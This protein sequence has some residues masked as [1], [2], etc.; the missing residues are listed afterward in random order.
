MDLSSGSPAPSGYIPTTS[1][2]TALCLIPPRHLWPSLERL[3]CRYDS[4]YDKWPPHINLV[5]PFVPIQDLPA[6]VERVVAGL[7]AWKSKRGP[8]ASDIQLNL[9]A[10]SY[11]EHKHSNTIYL[12]DSDPDRDSALTQLRSSV[13][14]GLGHKNV[15]SY[16]AHMSVGQT[17]DAQSDAHKFLMEKLA[18]LPAQQWSAEHL[19]VLTRD[20]EGQGPSMMRFWGAI[21]LRQTRLVQDASSV[22]LYEDRA[23]VR[24]ATRAT[25]VTNQTY[26]YSLSDETWI[27]AVTS[28]PNLLVASPETLIVATYNVLAEFIH[29]I[30]RERYPLLIDNLLGTAA[31]A[32]ILVLQEVT[33]DFLTHLLADDRLRSRYAFVSHGPP[34]QPDLDPLP[35]LL[36]QVILSKF[37]FELDLLPLKKQHKVSLIATFPSIAKQQADGVHHPLVLATCHLSRGLTDGAVSTKKGELQ[38]IIEHL[39][40]N[41]HDSPWILAGDFNLATSR[42]TINAALEKRSI[43]QHTVDQIHSIEQML[44]DCGLSDAWAVARC[45]VGES[46][47]DFRRPKDVRQTY[48]GEQGATFDPT[49]NKLAAE[50]VGTGFGNRPQRYDRILVKADGLFHVAGFSMFGFPAAATDNISGMPCASDHWGVR[51]L[52]RATSESSGVDSGPMT[53][54][55]ETKRAPEGLGGPEELKEYLSEIGGFPTEEDEAARTRAFE[56]LKSAILSAIGP[57]STQEDGRERQG[58]PLVVTPVGSFALGVW[59]RDSDVDCLCIGPF[60][61]RTFFSVVTRYLR[62]A[63]GIRVLRKV[64]ANTGV[65]LELEVGGV[66]MDLQY[67]AAASIAEGW[68]TVMNRPATDP[69]FSLPHL[70]LLKLKAARDM[71]YL[72]RSIP[73]LAQ[74]RLAYLLIKTWAKARGIYA[75]ML[76]YLGG[77]HIFTLLVPICKMLAHNGGSVSVS[78]VIV[79]FFDHYAHFDWAKNVVFDPFFHKRLRYTRTSREPLALLGWHG[80]SLNTALAASPPTVKAIATELQAANEQLGRSGVTWPSFL[81]VPDHC[82]PGEAL[83]PGGIGAAAFLRSFRSYVRLDVHYWGLSIERRNSLVGW[84]G[85]RCVSVLV[86]IDKKVPELV[87]RIWPS[88]FVSNTRSASDGGNG[89]EYGG[90]FL[91][92]LER[93]ED[94]GGDD[95]TTP[96]L[97]AAKGTLIGVL[98]QFETRV[99]SDEKYYDPKNSWIA[100]TVVS[101]S[102]LGD[103]ELDLDEWD[104]FGDFGDDNDSD[105]DD[106]D[107]FEEAA[108][109]S[110]SGEQGIAPLGEKKAKAIK[111]AGAGKLRP[112]ADVMNRLRWDDKMD[113]ADYLVGYEDRFVG[114]IEKGLGDWKTEQ[115]DEEFIPQHRIAY[116]KRRRDGVVVWDRAARID[117]IFGSG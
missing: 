53:V 110:P 112:A 103:L 92:G 21:D 78:D 42:Y 58:P 104:E 10:A 55:V 77:I 43:S 46:S 35:S 85:S 13:L 87:T 1:H 65:M 23:S 80:P 50:L 33:D 56:T 74:F 69:I 20:R 19:V 22:G 71:A 15:G 57:K 9:A 113:P 45:E 100:A 62:S 39:H 16:T 114:I 73:D 3:R 107:D 44:L 98:R 82:A 116:F 76:G 84:L 28:G 94:M 54:P 36:N 90:C 47:D 105:P 61:S 12:H 17:E 79:T 26:T 102:E 30:T 6:A 37:P 38:R 81:G 27:P 96:D 95:R 64:K 59:S 24:G 48:E 4:A 34:G 32:D 72:R 25:P 88:R 91:I 106:Y 60:S 14:Q 63:E 115:T 93:R 109:D 89:V 41:H 7:G 83:T 18:L 2:D 117:L 68:P 52:L 11:F 99:R 86:D 5:Y 31:A 75:A 101:G 66:K 40:R 108:G 29:P 67:C 111:P 8:Q 97:E 70:T 49:E 51:C